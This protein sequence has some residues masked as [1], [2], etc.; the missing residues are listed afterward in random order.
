MA[1]YRGVH[2]SGDRCVHVAKILASTDDSTADLCAVCMTAR[3]RQPENVAAA[4][5]HPSHLAVTPA[6]FTRLPLNKLAEI[7]IAR[8]G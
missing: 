5:R 2:L 7:G 8:I 6:P 4:D 3:W 1:V